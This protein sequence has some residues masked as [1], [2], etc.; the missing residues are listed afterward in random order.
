MENL[1]ANLFIADTSQA[2]LKVSEQIA[3]TVTASELTQVLS[4]FDSSLGGN[5]LEREA[6]LLGFAG[7]ALKP[8][9]LPF[10]IQYIP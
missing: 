6:A 5:G 1:I 3:S 4:K 7:L 10:L 2:V 8:L 9:A